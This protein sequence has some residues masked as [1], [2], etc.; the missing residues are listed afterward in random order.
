MPTIAD[1]VKTQTE[2]VLSEA[3]PES[4][5]RVSDYFEKA[6]KHQREAV[7]LFELGDDRQAEMHANIA[8]RH[9]QAGMDIRHPTVQQNSWH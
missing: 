8:R 4:H 7:R 5:R 2:E 6:S 9:A 1:Y 3:L